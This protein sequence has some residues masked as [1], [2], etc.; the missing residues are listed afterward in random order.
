MVEKIRLVFNI[1][2]L[3]LFIY[4][5]AILRFQMN[6]SFIL[7]N[8]Q[9]IAIYFLLVIIL[10]TPNIFLQDCILFQMGW[11]IHLLF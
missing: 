9:F 11:K 5:L 4:F 10:F 6:L 3:G 7:F 8:Y 1:I 2:F